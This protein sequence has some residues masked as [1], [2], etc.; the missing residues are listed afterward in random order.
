M[1]KFV[2]MSVNGE[3]ISSHNPN[4]CI[5]M[6]HGLGET[7]QVW[8]NCAEYL[9]ENLPVKILLPD[10][11]GAGQS[12]GYHQDDLKDLNFFAEEILSYIRKNWNKEEVIMICHSMGGYVALTIAE[13]I[14]S[15]I[16]GLFLCHSTPEADS[17][18][19]K[20]KRLQSIRLF[21]VNTYQYLNE[22]YKNLFA[23]ENQIVL[24]DIIEKLLNYGLTLKKELFLSTLFALKD[25]PDRFHIFRQLPAYKAILA[26]KYDN[27][28]DFE[29][30]QK[31]SEMSN[32]T[33]YPAFHSA[34]M[35]MFEEPGFLNEI[36]HNF[37][38][39]CINHFKLTT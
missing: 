8:N 30:L 31:I 38:E 35:V 18:E 28:L 9:V 14:P 29:K 27:I 15:L 32:A 6:L 21:Q 39:K 34:H 4:Y 25:R 2:T 16:H 7:H 23:S 10:L 19:R 36:L 12:Q 33:F 26:G 22:F 37:V 11:P 17:E 24:K 1:C 5:V 3:I 13:Q 20:Q